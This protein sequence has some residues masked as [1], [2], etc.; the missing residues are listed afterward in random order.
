MQTE[1]YDAAKEL[2]KRS[3]EVYQSKQ[4]QIR[5]QDNLNTIWDKGREELDTH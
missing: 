4:K 3:S 5:D 1:L 2:R